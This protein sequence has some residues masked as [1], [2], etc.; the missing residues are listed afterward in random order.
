V[1]RQ[2]LLPP[3]LLALLLTL[4]GCTD[5]SSGSPDAN[6]MAEAAWPTGEPVSF[7]F[8]THCGVESAQIGGFW[9]HAEKPLYGDGGE[10]VGPPAGWGDPY[11]QGL[12]TL[13]SPERAVFIA[14]GR[15]VVLRPA[16]T[17]KPLRVC[18]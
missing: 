13:E 11:Q 17:D 1:R 4:A 16:P 2:L 18:R 7:S 10:G 8:Y 12:L 5:E 15:E 3:L 6:A 14:M 9:W